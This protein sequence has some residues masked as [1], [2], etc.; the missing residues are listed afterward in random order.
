M[1]S[2]SASVRP[3]RRLKTSPGSE[4]GSHSIEERMRRVE[5]LLGLLPIRGSTSTPA[6][7][8]GGSSSY[9]PNQGNAGF[10]GSSPE[11]EDTPKFQL[12][13]DDEGNVSL[14]LTRNTV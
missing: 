1:L 4:T 3:L 6:S 5:E 11:Q 13:I 8:R 14:P 9:F 2:P 10:D 12:T 7:E